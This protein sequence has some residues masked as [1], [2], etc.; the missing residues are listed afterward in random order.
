ML[1]SKLLMNLGPLVLILLIVAVGAIWQLQATKARLDH[2]EATAWHSLDRNDPATGKHHGEILD[3]THVK[4]EELA[5]ITW[6]RRWVLVLTATLV[7]VVNYA[8]LLLL[9][10]AR[11]I[12]RPVDALVAGTRAVAEGR[13][14]HR[15][16]LPT[17][18]GEFSELARSFNRMA[19]RL[20]DSEA[21]QM[22]TVGQ[23]ALAMN[24]EINNAIAIIALQLKLLE[25]Q[26]PASPGMEK[27]LFQIQA[28]LERMTRALTAL[29][30]ARR[31]VLTEYLPGM[32]MLDLAKSQL[33]EELPPGES[34]AAAADSAADSATVNGIRRSPHRATSV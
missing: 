16:E 17:G 13:F 4:A 15:I 22:E 2:L 29:K 7:I 19:E 30:G 26:T 34:G 14:D 20:Q 25:R 10:V 24:H 9:H 1:R 3:L 12:V 5:L 21:L 11:I 6:F 8:V 32:K 28:S 18:A 23:V 33:P 27:Y 31:I